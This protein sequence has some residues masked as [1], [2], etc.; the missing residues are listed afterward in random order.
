[1]NR[2]VS[3]IAAVR[4]LI[5]GRVS[6][7]PRQ[8]GRSVNEQVVECTE[9]AEREGWEVVRVVRETASASRYARVERRFWDQ[10]VSSITDGEI[11]A[12]LT[13]ESSRATRDLEA[14][15]ALRSACVA[16]GVRWG[17]SGRLY[18][19]T[20]R[21]S[22]F[23]TGL[24]ALLAE[25]EAARTSER[26][27][28]NVRHAALAGR[29]HGK[30]LYG[31][32]RIYD[33]ETRELVRIE[34]DPMQAPIVQEAARRVLNGDTCYAVA[35]SFNE[36]G[37]APRRPAYKDH[38]RKLGWTPVAIKQM[39]TQPS[40]AGVRTHRGTIVADATWPALIERER[41]ERLQ[42][43]LFDPS[44]G[45]LRNDTAVHLLSGIAVCAICGG[46]MRVGLQNVGKTKLDA[47]G[48][49][50]PR[51]KYHTYICI[52]T[53]GKGGFHTAIKSAFLD[54]LVTEAVI[55][56]LERP[57][58]LQLLESTDSTRDD[59]R[60]ALR[61]EIERHQ[62]WLE[63][64]RERARRER[65][66]D[67]LFDQERR[68]QPLIEA[69]QRRLDRLAAADPAVLDM[70]RSPSPRQRWADL[71]LAT[72]R[73]IIRAVVSPRIHPAETRGQRT[74]ES[75]LRRVEP[76]WR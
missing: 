42:A 48:N 8:L 65:N 56:R 34:P 67:L 1:M 70:I 61:Q 41:W 53:P 21:D 28:R 39:L 4:V 7:D 40:Y 16:T 47:H 23:R 15:A 31:Y 33:P 68:T 12:L 69:A 58:A 38:R 32:R 72:R 37:V 26:I 3:I 24:D 43:I 49:R 9:W 11:D 10:V 13:W 22:R 73:R 44:R 71:D 19:L 20:D 35:K 74:T 2:L 60:A 5:Y 54:E 50:V 75:I 25:D 29:P 30:N 62:A 63:Q 55:I 18:D 6:R 76:V 66:L 46:Q 14:Y 27:L 51:E 64:V 45:M 57:D 52:G 36:R 59:E 17:Y